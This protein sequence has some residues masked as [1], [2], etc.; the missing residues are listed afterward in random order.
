[1][2]VGL[3]T[4]AIAFA[5][6]AGIINLVALVV[7]VGTGLI[8]SVLHLPNDLRTALVALGG[9]V[10]IVWSIAY[11]VGFWSTTGQTPG[12]RMMRFRVVP[13]EGGT[14]KPRRAVVRFIGLVLAA[15]PLL[16]GYLLILYDGRRR[17]FQDRLARTV[18]IEA[19]TLSAAEQ[20][21]RQRRASRVM[22][23]RFSPV[24]PDRFRPR[25]PSASPAQT[26]HP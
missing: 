16:A 23:D 15:L 9:V 2:Y 25:E 12:A 14:L 19:P 7:G 22:T 1:M 18:V 13:A 4:R 17:G 21:R 26:P 24:V 20:R 6:D 8:I 11:F 3:V 10:Y 5:I